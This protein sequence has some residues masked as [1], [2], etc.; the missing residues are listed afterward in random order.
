M[1]DKTSYAACSCTPHW[2]SLLTPYLSSSSRIWRWGKRGSCCCASWWTSYATYRLHVL[3]AGIR[4]IHGRV[5]GL[6]AYVLVLFTEAFLLP[7]IAFNKTSW[8]LY[9]MMRYKLI[10]H[11]ILESASRPIA[12][13]HFTTPSTWSKVSSHWTWVFLRVLNNYSKSYKND[14]AKTTQ[15]SFI[16]TAKHGWL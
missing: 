14:A 5:D 4:S 13:F 16:Y 1:R 10:S 15:E 9:S 12:L 8:F 2:F 6:C 3:G 7:E 11:A